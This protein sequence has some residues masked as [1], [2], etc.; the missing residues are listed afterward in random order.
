MYSLR[1]PSEEQIQSF[2]SQQE[3]APFSY[4][5]IGSTRGTPPRGYTVD[6]YRIKLGHGEKV[7]LAARSALKHWDMFQISWVKL[8]WPHKAPQEGVAFAVLVRC[9][10]LWVLNASRIVY[11][12]EEK[13]AVEKFG[14]AYG[15]LPAHV[16]K[17][18]ERFSVERHLSDDSV[19][20][21][22]FALSRPHQLLSHLGYP[23][24]RFLQSQFGHQ[25]LQA[26]ARAVASPRSPG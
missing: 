18:E 10:N 9:L 15:T 7:F 17:G 26:M 12:I 23:L 19:W 14:F 2:L 11:V 1:R 16:E 6:H 4:S 21:D 20:Y 13:G 8:C 24:V 22:I 3:K 5:E 25:S